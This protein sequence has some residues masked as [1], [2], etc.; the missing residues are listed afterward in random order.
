MAD[1]RIQVPS[2]AERGAAF[3]VKVLIR[4]P[5]EIGFRVDDDGKRIPRNVIRLVT[6]RYGGAEVFR[7]EPSSGISANPY[8]AF[9][10]I[11]R[12]SGELVLEWVDDAGERAS[13]S[14]SVVVG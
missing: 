12:E 14:A 2:R 3:E 4:H 5:M 9:P 11:A 7:I 8:F 13:A 1:A 10:V 6:C